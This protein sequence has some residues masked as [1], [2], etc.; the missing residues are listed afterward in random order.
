MVPFASRQSK[1]MLLSLPYSFLHRLMHTYSEKPMT[2]FE[3]L[4]WNVWLPKVRSSINNDWDP[5]HPQSAVKLYEAW[6]SFLPPFIRDNLLDQLILP[7]MQKAVAEWKPKTATVSLRAIVFPWLPHVGLRLEDVV[8]D[9]KRKVKSLLRSWTAGDNVPQD[10]AAWKDVFDSNDWDSIILKYVVPKLG[11]ILRT[12]FHINPRNQDMKPL[13]QVLAWVHLTRP[14]IFSQLIETEFIPKWLDIL[15]VWLIQPKVSFEEV[16][17]WYQF[18]KGSFP[19]DVQEMEGVK[20]GFTRGL[21]LMNEAIALGDD[22]PTKLPR[23]DFLA[24]QQAASRTTAAAKPARATA[25]RTY[26]IT[27][28]SIVEEF[29]ASHN[30]LFLPAG[31]AHEKS[32]MPL[33]RVSPSADGKGGLLVYI[34]DDAVWASEKGVG[35]PTEDYRAIPLED[36]VLRANASA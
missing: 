30:L 15:H 5:C 8:G 21:Q 10:L 16:A 4:L 31:K 35:G 26:E 14:R 11:A 33:F 20:K 36:V 34:L 17:Q 32:R 3:S 9:A 25:A 24:E 27:F 2:P 6:S 29:V 7:K 12:D 1:C 19:E 18:W 28:R 13:E 22:A 23:P